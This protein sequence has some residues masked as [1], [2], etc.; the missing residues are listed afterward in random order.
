MRRN[1]MAA[2]M[3][4][5]AFGITVGVVTACSGSDTGPDTKPTPTVNVTVET[6]PN[7]IVAGGTYTFSATVTGSTNTAVLWSVDASGNTNVG[8][9][10]NGGVYTAPP[11]SGRFTVRATSVAD[12]TKSGSALVLVTAAPVTVSVLP[13]TISVGAGGVVQLTATVAGSANGAVTWELPG[14]TS[15]GT[16]TSTGTAN[17]T[18]TAPTTLGTYQVRARS[19]A[20]TSKT[21]NAVITVAAGSGFRISGS[22][23]VAPNTSTQFN[24][25]FN[26]VTTP[27]TWS[28]DA[29]ANGSTISSAGVFAAGTTQ[30]VVTVRA[31][32]TQGRV[33]TA[34]VNVATQVTLDIL[35]QANPTLSTADMLTFYWSVTPSGVSSDVTWSVN[36]T[37]GG[38]TIP[39]DYFRGFIPSSTPGAVTLTAT[40]VADPTVTKSFVATVTAAS[41]TTFLGPSA[42]PQ[43]ARYEH[44]AAT[45]PDGR[46]V[47]LGGQRSRG[48]YTPLT[49][50]EIFNPA[51]ATF[52]AGPA[53]QSIRRMSEAVA[54]DANRVLI[55]GGVED[56]NL[57]YNTGEVVNI[58]AGTSSLVANAMSTRRLLHQMAPI[59]TGANAGKIAILGGF[60]GPIPYG[61]PVWQSSAAVDLYDVATNRFTTYTASM[62]SARGQ[63]TATPLNDG[64]I[65]IVGGYDASTSSALS[66]AEIFDPV[67]GTFTFTGNMS[68]ARSGHTATRLANGMVLIVGGSNNGTDGNSAEL[69]NPATGLFEAAN[70]SMI[71][72]RTNH[73]AALLGDGR[74]AIIGGESGEYFVRGSVEV[75][76][77]A[78]RTFSMLG[79]MT[80]ARRRPT[81]S[82]LTTGLYAGRILVFGGSAEDKVNL[83]AE[84]VR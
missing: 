30:G 33:A 68:R 39:V 71:V 40:S 53:L 19:S 52:L 43:S 77:P 51:D 35:V 59:T 1:V 2:A 63:F 73:A 38:T 56:Y 9:I 60:N 31:V 18:Y 46:I 21:A 41:A 83:A 36:P 47:L 5:A 14:G 24:A 61:V 42:V 37:S 80:T 69:Y 23:R 84:I 81:A 48:L 67:A 58:G 17:A 66:S 20:D 55:T 4:A 15:T 75:Y 57:A 79:R 76:D 65:L 12:P 50:S 82:A 25:S 70:G 78:A 29:P 32:D 3:R 28:I 74:V 45:L 7:A 6:P 62:R 64:R 13:A 27:V 49:T 72:S 10:N 54:I 26:D 16:V 22:A 11:A 8:T 34:A 44:T